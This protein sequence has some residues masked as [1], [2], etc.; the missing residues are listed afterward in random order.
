MELPLQRL[1][2]QHELVI[3]PPPND[4]DV[5]KHARTHFR[6]TYR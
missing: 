3:N 1:V 2:E 4:C 6:M 5:S